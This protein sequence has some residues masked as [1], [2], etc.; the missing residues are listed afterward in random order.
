MNATSIQK[1]DVLS[2]AELVAKSPDPVAAI[3]NLGRTVA[4]SQMMG[5][6]DR[7]E[8]GE[9]IVMLCITS[10]WTLAEVFR[11]YQISFGRLE[12]RIDAAMAEFKARGGKVE[13]IADGSDGKQARAKFT[14]ADETLEAGCTTDEAQKAGWF[15]NGKWATEPQTMLRARV[16]KRGIV[17][18]C[19]DI[20][21]GEYADEDRPEATVELSAE[22]MAVAA[23]AV[24]T[25]PK[26]APAPA[27]APA[28]TPAP[29]T[30]PATSPAPV[31]AP[32][33]VNVPTAQAG[34]VP[35]STELQDKLVEII[36]GEKM[37]SAQAWAKSVGWLPEDGT[38]EEL[39]EKHARAIIAKPDR[40]KVALEAFIAKGAAK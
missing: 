34:A 14:M 25:T 10:G 40:F 33:V 17:A 26:P 5:P 11:T 13:W 38:I 3:Q 36:G 2:M 39:P 12:K 23:A 32:S 24:A 29:V 8:I 7:A 20:F 30:A 21:F 6:C 9:V 15:K 37:A 28:A 22:K 18:L 35:L 1:P 19:P 27:P 31:A 4:R 16:K